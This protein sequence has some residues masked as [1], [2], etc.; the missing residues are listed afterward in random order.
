MNRA[1]ADSRPRSVESKR[2]SDDMAKPSPL[3]KFVTN[4]GVATHNVLEMPRVPDYIRNF[5]SSPEWKKAWGDYEGRLDQWRK[6]LALQLNAK[7]QAAA[8]STTVPTP[9]DVPAVLP[10]WDQVNSKP[11]TFPP[12]AHGHPISDIEGLAAALEA[13]L[14]GVGGLEEE[15]DER[16]VFVKTDTTTE[17]TVVPQSCA[18]VT[19]DI[20][21]V[22]EAFTIDASG[23]LVDLSANL[24][25]VALQFGS[26]QIV[27]GLS[28]SVYWRLTGSVTIR[29][30][31]ATG[32]ALVEASL[33]LSDSSVTVL[34]NTLTIDTT[35][36]VDFDIL[37]NML[38]VEVANYI[39]CKSLL[40][41][42]L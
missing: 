33:A 28:G 37:I 19:V 7:A 5:H 8:A 42:K 38:A 3:D 16:T 30:I 15:A 39:D 27:F 35:A 23:T 12:S 6:N 24:A 20:V 25:Q 9:S 14:A 11:A 22:G 4:A 2:A 32:T 13:L 26:S 17:D 10:S 36:P 40:I 21:E 31:G 18:G 1:L 41:Q 29:T 34:S